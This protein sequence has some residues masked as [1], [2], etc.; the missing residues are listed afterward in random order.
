MN[1]VNENTSLDQGDIGIKQMKDMME[2][3]NDTN[4][5][6][7]SFSFLQE[8]EEHNQER[9]EFIKKTTGMEIDEDV[10]NN[11]R[12]YLKV[13]EVTGREQIYTGKEAVRMIKNFNKVYLDSNPDKKVDT[14]LIDDFNE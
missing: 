11:G 12:L 9:N 7:G 1:A 6:S 10:D 14:S 4:S 2:S 3:S 5:F 8:F 13:V